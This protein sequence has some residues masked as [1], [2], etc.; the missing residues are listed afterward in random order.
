MVRHTR[1]QPCP[2][3]RQ[4]SRAWPA[5]R[6]L[7]GPI[8]LPRRRAPQQVGAALSIQVPARLAAQQRG[9]QRLHLLPGAA[10]RGVE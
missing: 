3:V 9:Q 8:C 4:I 1:W 2:A 5:G 6:R 10:G 7:G